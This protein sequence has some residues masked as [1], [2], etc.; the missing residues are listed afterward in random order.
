MVELFSQRID[1]CLC[2]MLSF[3]FVSRVMGA[4]FHDGSSTRH[5]VISLKGFL[6]FQHAEAAIGAV[7]VRNLASFS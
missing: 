7:D 4:I 2:M 6:A 5:H 3:C 1:R